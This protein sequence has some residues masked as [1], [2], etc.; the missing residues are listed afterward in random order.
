MRIIDNSYKIVVFSLFCVLTRTAMPV[1]LAAH[2]LP[3]LH[4]P[5]TVCCNITLIKR[6]GKNTTKP[7][8]SGSYF[9]PVAKNLSQTGTQSEEVHQISLSLS[10]CLLVP[11]FRTFFISISCDDPQLRCCNPIGVT[12]PKLKNTNTVC[13]KHS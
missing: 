1:L 2:S 6:A 12:I 9:S 4:P 7:G 5:C 3:L 13:F 10:C 11:W 8:T